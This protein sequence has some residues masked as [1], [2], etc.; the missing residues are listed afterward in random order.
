MKSITGNERVGR[1]AYDTFR[2]YTQ[3]PGPYWSA[4]PDHVKRAWQAVALGVRA[5]LYGEIEQAKRHRP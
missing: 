4:L 3:A 5:D 2:R 1:L